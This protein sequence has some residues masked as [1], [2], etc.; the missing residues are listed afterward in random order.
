[1][2]RVPGRVGWPPGASCSCLGGKHPRTCWGHLVLGDVSAAGCP[3]SVPH[4]RA[5]VRP[6]SLSLPS[7]PHPVSAAPSTLSYRKLCLVSQPGSWPPIP[8]GVLD[9]GIAAPCTWGHL[10]PPLMKVLCC[11]CSGTTPARDQALFSIPAV[12]GARVQGS[13]SRPCTSTRPS[14]SMGSGASGRH[15]P[16]PHGPCSVWVCPA[17]LSRRQLTDSV[18]EEVG[19]QGLSLLLPL[20]PF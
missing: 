14:S 8:K 2:P 9:R 10:P 6:L 7:L 19:V 18:A 12:K 5:T 20:P 1:M 3:T 13:S 15:V 4:G 16:S 17:P 11:P